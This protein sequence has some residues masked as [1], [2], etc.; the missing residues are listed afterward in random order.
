MVKYLGMVLAVA[1]SLMI[2][3]QAQ[4]FGR[5]HGCKSCGGCPGGNCSVPYADAGKQASTN[6]APPGLAAAPV[7]TP[8]PA[9]VTVAQPTTTTYAYN[10]GRRG[11]FGRR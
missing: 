4:A 1:G 8:A 9:I 3:E 5:H 11:L 7:S 10:T 2:A 6:N